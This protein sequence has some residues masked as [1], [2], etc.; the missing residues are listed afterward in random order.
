MQDLWI[1]SKSCF[2]GGIEIYLAE[3]SHVFED[4]WRE[5]IWDNDAIVFQDVE[6]LSSCGIRVLNALLLGLG[7]VFSFVNVCI[8]LALLGELCVV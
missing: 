7:L 8:M 4:P 3:I 5:I 1:G 6:E 2:D